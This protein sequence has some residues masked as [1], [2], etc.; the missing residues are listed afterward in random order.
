MGGRRTGE[1]HVQSGGGAAVAAHISNTCLGAGAHGWRAQLQR[2]V[3][4]LTPAD[5]PL[6][7]DVVRALLQGV[8][9]P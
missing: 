3:D 6:V 5:V 8:R 9:P 7:P 1:A 2:E 4:L